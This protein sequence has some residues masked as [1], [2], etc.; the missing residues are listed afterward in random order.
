MSRRTYFVIV[1]IVLAALATTVAPWTLSSGGFAAS[2]AEQ[3]RDGYG[4]N[5]DVRGRSTFALL[6]VPRLKFEDVTLASSD[7]AIRAEGG[8]LRGELRAISL[9]RGRI[10]LSE[11]ALADS[12]ITLADR[13]VPSFDLGRAVALFGEQSEISR[14]RRLSLSG[15]SVQWSSGASGSIDRV[16]GIVSWRDPHDRLEMN[17]WGFWRGERVEV[18]HATIDPTLAASGRPSPFTLG[19]IGAG[20]QLVAT[21][22]AQFGAD[23][24]ITGQ[25]TLGF[26]S[27]RDFSRWSGLDLPLGSLMQAVSIDGDFSA[28]RRRIGWPSVALKLGSDKLEGA[29]AV[30]LDSPRP[31]VTGTL[32]ADQLNLSDFFSAF[33]Q[34]RTGSGPWSGDDITLQGSTS[35][36]LD[37]RLSA[38]DSKLGRLRVSDMAAS[39]LVRPGRIEASL[40]RASVRNGS[41]KGRLT[42]ASANGGTEVKAQGAFDQVDLAAVLNDFGQRRWITGQAQG[43]FALEGSGKTVADLVRQTQGKTT[44]TVKQG[45]ILGIGLNDVLRRA[46]KQPLSAFL[47][48]R[49][50]RTAFDQAWVNLAFGAGI[51]EIVDGALQAPAIYTALEG[52]LSLTD[53]SLAMRAHVNPGPAGSVT[54]TS[55]SVEFNVSGSWDDVDVIPDVKALIERSG[56]AKRLLGLDRLPTGALDASAAPLNSAR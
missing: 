48:W 39:V 10:E 2:V 54:P 25:S 37:L 22:E 18:T 47:D 36:D 9:L 38:T 21:G 32:A 8:T 35:G 43:H 42:L 55:P 23:P 30:R 31:V 27:V 53:R 12:R 56:A 19:I 6:P 44:I 20:A 49:G 14:V 51:G 45:E 33:S 41:L 5:L 24:R 4:I 34:A 52:R 26:R 17:G 11:V 46:E 29:L 1:L 28:D 40:G 7:G 13:V 50:G 3:L 15:S 16:T